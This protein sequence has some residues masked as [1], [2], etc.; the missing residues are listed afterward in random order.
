MVLNLAEQR[1]SEK[2]EISS[3]WPT[4]LTK[5]DLRKTVG[6]EGMMARMK[7]YSQ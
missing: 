3:H 2:A 4:I 1:G 6:V 5:A 7:K